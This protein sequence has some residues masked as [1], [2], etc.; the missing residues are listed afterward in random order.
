MN[1]AVANDYV[2]GHSNHELE[3]LIAQSRY[4]GELTVQLL[5]S[6][7]I[8]PG[9]RVLDVGC[10]A[11]DVSFLLA[12]RVGATGEVIGVDRSVDAVHLAT[13]RA[14]RAGL[15][16]V[17]FLAH[18]LQTFAPGQWFDAVVGRLVLMYF[19]DPVP[20]LRRLVRMTR[21]G[22]VIAF[23]EIDVTLAASEPH[24]PLYALAVRRIAETFRRAGADPRMGVRLPQT[25]RDAGLPPPGL[26]AHTRIGACGDTSPFEQVA[27]I[28]RTLAPSMEKLGIARAADVDVETLAARLA[29]EAA[30]EDATVIAPLFI[31]AWSRV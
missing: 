17:R 9:M 28:T 26:I 16:N 22:G 24:L 14:A 21:P 31:G 4:F 10:G 3:R 27:N 12:N 19:Q 18:D 20:L 11:G 2:L 15:T 13:Q 8:G 5:S 1:T 25:F 6:A 7:G 30:E 29:E 23:H